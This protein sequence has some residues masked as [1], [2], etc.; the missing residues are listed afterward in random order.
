MTKMSVAIGANDFLPND[1]ATVVVDCTYFVACEGQPET[2]PASAG[3]ELMLRTEQL[4]TATYTLVDA[5]ILVIDE[6]A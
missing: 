3:V 2:R 1:A 4:S 5:V 6:L